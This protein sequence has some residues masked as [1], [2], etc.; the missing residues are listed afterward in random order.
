MLDV[1]V[2]AINRDLRVVLVDDHFFAIAEKRNGQIVLDKMSGEITTYEATYS[3]GD[4]IKKWEDLEEFV[5]DFLDE[6]IYFS[7]W[8]ALI[9]RSGS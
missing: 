7:D 9:K 5:Y 1:E 8:D 2:K 4:P 3:N 6:I